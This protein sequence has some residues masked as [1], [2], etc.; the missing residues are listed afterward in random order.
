MKDM[1]YQSVW[2]EREKEEKKKGDVVIE[3]AKSIAEVLKKK[4]HA[5]EVFLLGSLIRGPDF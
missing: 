2:E 5:K 3:K 4:Y 1:E